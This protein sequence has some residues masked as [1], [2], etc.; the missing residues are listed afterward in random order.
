MPQGR[1]LRPVL[2]LPHAGGPCFNL[3][4]CALPAP[5]PAASPDKDVG[6]LY[7]GTLSNNLRAKLNGK[8]KKGKEEAED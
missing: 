5:A 4:M 3:C 6:C 2:C 7:W 8:S 1:S